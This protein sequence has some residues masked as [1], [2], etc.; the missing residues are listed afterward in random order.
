MQRRH[1]VH[2]HSESERE[3]SE[4]E[5][6]GGDIENSPTHGREDELHE[7]DGYDEDLEEAIG[8]ASMPDEETEESEHKREPRKRK[9][10]D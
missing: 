9:G 8:V 5:T 3:E 6:E 10:I 7:E 4:Y 1:Q 2:E